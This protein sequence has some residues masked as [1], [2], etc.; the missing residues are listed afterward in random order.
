MW[1]ISS[2]SA[3][4]GGLEQV[5]AVRKGLRVSFRVP[6]E[7]RGE[8]GKFVATCYLLDAPREAP[9]KDAVIRHVADAVRS[10]LYLR[11]RDRTLDAFLREHDLSVH[12][13]VEGIQPGSYIDVTVSLRAA[14]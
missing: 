5:A 6:V 4:L 3:A 10:L 8:D 7:V 11:L 13:A 1:N 14:G 12:E 9:S 2:R